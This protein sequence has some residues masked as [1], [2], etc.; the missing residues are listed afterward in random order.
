MVKTSPSSV[1]SVGSI[2]GL[3]AKILHASWPKNQNRNN[4]ITIS[5]KIFSKKEV[6]RA[7]SRQKDI[8]GLHCI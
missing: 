8:S 3:G 5:V 1:E 2:P 7:G 4:V 6:N